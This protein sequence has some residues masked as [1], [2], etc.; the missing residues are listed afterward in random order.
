MRRKA[1]LHLAERGEDIDVAKIARRPRNR[2]EADMCRIN[3]RC[4]NGR[5]GSRG[6]SE[7]ADRSAGGEVEGGER[8]LPDENEAGA[9]HSYSQ[10]R[11]A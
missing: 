4:F 2:P 3:G 10:R 9:T 8:C 6:V 1:G 5:A 7:R 11:S